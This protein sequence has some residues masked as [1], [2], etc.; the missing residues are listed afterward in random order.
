MATATSGFSEESGFDGN[1]QQFLT[2]RVS[3][4]LGG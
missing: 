1:D 4:F 2:G 3:I